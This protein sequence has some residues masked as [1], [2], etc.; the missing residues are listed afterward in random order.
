MADHSVRRLK[1]LNRSIFIELDGI[2][3]QS[4]LGLAAGLTAVGEP[5]FSIRPG[6]DGDVAA[7]EDL[8]SH[9]SNFQSFKSGE[10]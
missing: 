8:T 7:E 4:A 5:L 9:F 1:W 6:K 10:E 3:A 2:N